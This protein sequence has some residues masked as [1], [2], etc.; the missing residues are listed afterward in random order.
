MAEPNHDVTELLDALRA[1][2][3]GASERLMAV[4][5]A[6]LRGLAASYMR[7]E[8]DDHTLQPTALVHEAFLRLVRQRETSWQN[9]SHFFGVAAQ[10][11]RRVLLD[12]A[13][14]RGRLKRRDLD[15]LPLA[16]IDP[17]GDAPAT[18]VLDLIAVDDALARLEVLDPR[19]ARVVEARFFAGL[20]VEETA[21]ALGLSTPTVKRDWAF[22]RAF[23]QR[24]LDDA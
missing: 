7:R 21:E 5:Y 6:E 22:A 20:S 8:R 17:G 15:P 10:A 13:R 11:M 14:A 3:P 12:H 23:L 1:G 19:A 4:I 16:M 2:V 9:R 24:Q 18:D